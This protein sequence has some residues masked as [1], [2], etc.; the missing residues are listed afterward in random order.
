M[1]SSPQPEKNQT[2]CK[3]RIVGVRWRETCFFCQHFLQHLIKICAVLE[4]IPNVWKTI[5]VGQGVCMSNFLSLIYQDCLPAR[6]QRF[7][8]SAKSLQMISWTWPLLLGVLQLPSRKRCRDGIGKAVIALWLLCQ[9][10]GNSVCKVVL[11]AQL[12]LLK[13][14]QRQTQVLML[15]SQP[16]Q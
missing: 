4:D 15:G 13:S 3:M 6:V 7:S 2:S 11:R 5:N 9:G 12:S 16:T 10:F 14:E 8:W 1:S